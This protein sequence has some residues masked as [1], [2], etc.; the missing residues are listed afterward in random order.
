MD[1]EGRVMGMVSNFWRVTEGMKYR[2]SEDFQVSNN[3]PFII[4]L[5]MSV[6]INLVLVPNNA[7]FPLPIHQCNFTST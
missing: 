3:V 6:S 7:E 2:C 5:G 1:K 4:P